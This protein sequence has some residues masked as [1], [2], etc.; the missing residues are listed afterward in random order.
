MGKKIRILSIDG[1]GIRGVI[2]GVILMQVEKTI[3]QKTGNSQAK[4]ADYFDFFAGTSTGGILAGIYLCPDDQHPDKPRFTAE[5]A[6]ELY[7]RR[8]PLIFNST[9]WKRFTSFG[10]LNEEKYS[11]IVL[12][13]YLR[14]YFRDIKLSELVKPCLIAAYEIERRHAFFFS[15]DDAREFTDK[16]FFIRDV[17]RATSAAP[18]YFKASQIAAMSGSLFSFVDGGLVAN[19]PAMCALTE[20]LKC[21]G[22]QK[23]PFPVEDVVL[24]SMGTG[25]K[26]NPIEYK[27]AR[28]FGALG[29]IKPILHIVSSGNNEIVDYQAAHIFRNA[30]V[31][32]QYLRLSP[33]LLTASIDMD[34]A[35]PENM[36]ALQEAGIHCA[37]ENMAKIEALVDKL[38]ME[39]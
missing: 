13:K 26:K 37:E 25:I 33:Q 24:L 31:E 39:E 18:I 7:L 8:G 5:Q 3:Q 19:N 10:G 9:A 23:N 22:K 29:W 30:G 27:T 21:D 2:P 35:S 4:L 11:E 36:K 34:D 15:R 32:D 28:E 1:G 16:D 20:V 6:V 14:A 38:L 12:E 17:A